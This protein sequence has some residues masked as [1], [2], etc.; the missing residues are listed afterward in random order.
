V[1][2]V[3]TGVEGINLN[4]RT[5][6]PT[7]ARRILGSGVTSE[8]SLARHRMHDA[9]RPCSFRDLGPGP[10]HARRTGAGQR[11]M[12]VGAAADTDTGR[13]SVRLAVLQHRARRRL[14]RKR[15]LV[16]VPSPFLSPAATPGSQA[17]TNGPFEGSMRSEDR[18]PSAHLL[19]NVFTTRAEKSS[20]SQV[21]PSPACNVSRRPRGWRVEVAH[22]AVRAAGL[23][24]L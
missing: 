21:I 1:V 7:A 6:D 15:C 12:A 16:R 22:A 23:Y 14:E 4:D 13:K 18:Y 9:R 24:Q 11:A 8:P 10:R 2:P 3:R 17:L 19:S 5:V 20:A